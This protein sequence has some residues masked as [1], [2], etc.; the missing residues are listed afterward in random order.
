MAFFK[1][2]AVGAAR[3]MRA[4]RNHS[5]SPMAAR[6][7]KLLQGRILTADFAGLGMSKRP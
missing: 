1:L 7:I 6:G 3:R 2:F 4:S 5:S